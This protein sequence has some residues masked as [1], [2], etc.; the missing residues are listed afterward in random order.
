MSN[1]EKKRV[2]KNNISSIMSNIK[3]ALL[4]LSWTNYRQ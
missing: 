2:K 1:M 3:D 4:D